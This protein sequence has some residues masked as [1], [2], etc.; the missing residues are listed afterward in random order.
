MAE[1]TTVDEGRE[2]LLTVTDGDM[3]D[4]IWEPVDV[5]DNDEACGILFK[6]L[7][8]IPTKVLKESDDADCC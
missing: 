1:G 6:L 4:D 3:C 7:P 2:V 5:R 8:A